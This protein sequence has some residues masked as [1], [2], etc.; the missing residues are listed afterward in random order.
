MTQ[1]RFITLAA[2]LEA[3]YGTA[4]KI[5]TARAWITAGKIQ[6]TPQKIGREYFVEPAARYTEPAKRNRM[7]LL[8]RVKAGEHG[9]TAS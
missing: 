9:T 2:W 5:A 8:D 6:P 7:R 4:V 3:N 1:P